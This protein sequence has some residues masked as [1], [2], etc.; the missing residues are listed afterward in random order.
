MTV[1]RSFARLYTVEQ[2]EEKLLQAAE[3]VDKQA[4]LITSASTGGGASYG[5]TLVTKAQERVELYEAALAV[6]LGRDPEEDMDD[7]SQ[8]ARPHFVNFR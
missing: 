5:R 6:K 8:I 4:A 7:V 1:A 3:D 2:L